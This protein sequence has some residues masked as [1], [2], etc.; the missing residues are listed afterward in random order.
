M[1]ND[2]L[3]DRMKM[4]E[5]AGTH[6]LLPMLPIIARLDGKA[7][8]SFTKGLHKPFDDNFMTLMANTTKYLVEET[9]AIIGYTQSDEITLIYYSDNFKSQ[10]FM[11]GKHSKM[12]S[13]LSSMT[14]AYFNRHLSTYLPSKSS[15]CPLFDCRV[16]NV[17]TKTEAVN[18]LIW[19]EQDAVR[20]SISMLAQNYFSHKELHK[21]SCDEMQEMLFIEHGINWNDLPATKKRGSYILRRKTRA[22]FSVEELE[23]L[24]LKH[25]AR[26]N[27]NLVVERNIVLPLDLPIL[28]KIANREDV[29]FNGASPIFS[30]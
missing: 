1:Q 14:T 17:P 2:D 27:P 12:I 16:F 5:K 21:K 20:N 28:T 10:V 24:P 3:G 25:N 18:N 23:N 4:Y 29:V 9:N 6:Q 8:H 7:F 22:P 13:I 30:S 19:R 26:K 11:G 15:C